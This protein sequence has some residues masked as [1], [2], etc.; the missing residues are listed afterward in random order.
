MIFYSLHH[1]LIQL[2]GEVIYADA[3]SG[4]F[5][6]VAPYVEPVQ[7][8]EQKL[9]Q[10]QIMIQTLNDEVN[11]VI[12]PLERAVKLH[13]A[14]YAETVKLEAWERYSVELSRVDTSNPDAAL[15]DKPE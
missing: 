5:A 3:I 12:A 8:P 7:T 6:T 10:F 1:Q 9:Y 2:D 11:S 14:T 13:M 15:P 4:K